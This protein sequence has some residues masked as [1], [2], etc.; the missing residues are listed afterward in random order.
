LGKRLFNVDTKLGAD[1]RACSL[2]QLIFYHECGVI[3]RL[4]APHCGF[5]NSKKYS[6]YKDHF[7]YRLQVHLQNGQIKFIYQGHRIM[8]KVT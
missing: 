5:C 6:T 1:P 7:R 3:M 4:V 8:V 2:L